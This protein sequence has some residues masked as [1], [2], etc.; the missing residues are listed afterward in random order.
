MDYQENGEINYS[1]FLAATLSAKNIPDMESLIWVIFK[2][3]DIDNQ[4]VLTRDTIFEALLK[5][6]KIIS[7]RDLDLIFKEHNPRRN[8]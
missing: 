5:S 8:G 2:H 7:K 6:G 3:F 4:E 1:E